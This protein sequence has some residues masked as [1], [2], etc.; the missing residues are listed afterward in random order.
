MMLQLFHGVCDRGLG[1]RKALHERSGSC[2]IGKNLVLGP[3]RSIAR[4]L[5]TEAQ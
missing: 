1:I 4:V 2:P 5:S 3:A